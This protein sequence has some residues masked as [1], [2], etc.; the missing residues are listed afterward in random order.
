MIPKT[1]HENFLA[2]IAGNPYDTAIEPKTRYEHFLNDIARGNMSFFDDVSAPMVPTTKVTFAVSD[3]VPGTELAVPHVRASAQSET[4]R[5]DFT[6]TAI[7]ISVD[8]GTEEPVAF[9]GLDEGS[10]WEMTA[11]KGEDSGYIFTLYYYGPDYYKYVGD[12]TICVTAY[13]RKLNDEFLEAVKEALKI[14]EKVDE[15][16]S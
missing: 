6:P 12:H 10:A 9:G 14:L 15:T 8:G 2:K 11:Q 3:V 7:R 16:L 4:E 5:L 1:R 13:G